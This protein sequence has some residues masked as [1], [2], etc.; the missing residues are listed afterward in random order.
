MAGD[1][2]EERRKNHEFATTSA[3]HLQA[4]GSRLIRSRHPFTLMSQVGHQNERDG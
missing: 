2:E 4:M 3:R 1:Y